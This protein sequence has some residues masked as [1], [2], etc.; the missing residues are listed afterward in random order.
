M[1][2]QDPTKRLR[3]ASRLNPETGCI[4]W[5]RPT[6]E[7]GYGRLMIGKRRIMAHR[8]AWQIENGPI[9]DGMSVCHRC[10]NPKCINPAHLFLGTNVDNMADM[11]AKGR[12]NGPRGAD[13]YMAKLTDENVA[14]IKQMLPYMSQMQIAALFGVSQSTV[15]LI[16]LGKVWKHVRAE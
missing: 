1:K 8:L 6:T 14:S 16:A 7:N 2:S 15:S 4:E 10:D 12:G 11:K 5:M 13:N 3:D 9:P